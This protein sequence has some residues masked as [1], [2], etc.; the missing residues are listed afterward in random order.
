MSTGTV[1]SVAKDALAQEFDEL[2][3][4]HY[5]LVYRTAFSV[6]GNTEDA[7]DV[8]QALFMRLYQAGVPLRFK[9][10]L[11]GYL[12]RAAVNMSLNV[13]R[14]R[15]RHVL[16]SDLTQ[17]ERPA[18]PESPDADPDIQTRLVEAIAT[19]N[20]SAVEMLVL[21]YEHKYSEAEIGKLL[22]RSRGVVKRSEQNVE[23]VLK[24]SL[25]S[26]S[27]EQI[28]SARERLYVRATSNTGRARLAEMSDGLESMRP[29]S[30]LRW[31]RLAM[32]AAMVA[33]VAFVAALSPNIRQA[34]YPRQ[35]RW[36]PGI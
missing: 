20:P 22:G 26:A 9:D 7:E 11:K 6:T 10:N 2:F 14:S 16:T 35:R 5:P 36:A 21:R 30:R 17:L 1:F 23:A 31:P 12:Y 8:V 32:A 25:P 18:A 4:E 3:R 33:A 19:L 28:E 15:K 34:R 24:S 27:T 29:A 13:V